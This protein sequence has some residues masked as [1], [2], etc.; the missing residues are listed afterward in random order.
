[1]ANIR[2][3][4]TLT[5]EVKE[6]IQDISAAAASNNNRHNLGKQMIMKESQKNQRGTTIEYREPNRFYNDFFMVFCFR[7][8]LLGESNS[9]NLKKAFSSVRQKI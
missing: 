9:N 5:S 4:L 7:T 2:T 3:P 6:M 1:M 8:E